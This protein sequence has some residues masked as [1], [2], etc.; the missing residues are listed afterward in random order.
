MQTKLERVGHLPGSL[1]TAE[2]VAAFHVPQDPPDGYV[3]EPDAVYGT[4]GA[5]GRQLL[6][7]VYRPR[8]PATP[9]PAVVFV[10]GGAWAGGHPS[11]HTRLAALLAGDGY[12]TACIH[13]RL[14]GEAPW[15]AALEDA[16]CAVR[17]LRAE[18]ERLGVDP[19]RIAIAGG[20]AGG[21]LAAL[22]AFTPGRLEGSG[23]HAGHS[24]A[25]AAVATL[26][27][28]TDLRFPGV[29]PVNGATLREHADAFLAGADPSEADP[30]TYITG[31]APPVLTL[32]GDVDQAAPLPSIERLHA[33]LEGAG[34][35]NELVVYEGRDH[36][37]DFQ[38]RDWWDTAERFR[39][40]F[41][42]HLKPAFPVFHKR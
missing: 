41:A 8:I 25:V 28:G 6:A 29:D 1:L 31:D 24:S 16:K 32:V 23:G 34:V 12:V 26:Y 40:F 7:Q 39:R 20:S 2:D 22:V 3:Y 21:H 36:A 15:P 10:H 33:A 11:M 13:Y 42:R 4:A 27:P 9:R 5:G 14:S 38:P 18:H 17:W 19:D 30:V 35:P 37:F